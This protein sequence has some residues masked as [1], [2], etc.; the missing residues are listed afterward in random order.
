MFGNRV[1]AEE[2][3]EPTG[4]TTSMA[5]RQVERAFFTTSAILFPWHRLH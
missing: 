3:S 1:F 2:A 4:N 5:Y